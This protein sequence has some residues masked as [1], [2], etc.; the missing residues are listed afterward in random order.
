[1]EMQEEKECKNRNI[2]KLKSNYFTELQSCE[3]Q[4]RPEVCRD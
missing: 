1:M 3:K 2:R 4:I